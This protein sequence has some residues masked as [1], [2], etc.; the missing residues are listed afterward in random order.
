MLLTAVVC[1]LAVNRAKN[2]EYQ[3]ALDRLWG[4]RAVVGAEKD[5]SVR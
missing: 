5:D 3:W 4:N 2:D 1:F